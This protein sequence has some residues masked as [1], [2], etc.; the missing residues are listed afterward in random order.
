ML[1]AA[2]AL[3]RDVPHPAQAAI[4]ERLEH[5]LCRC[6]AHPRI[7]AAVADVAAPEARS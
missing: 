4:A 2:Y 3:L 5:N 6:G 1:M 7:L